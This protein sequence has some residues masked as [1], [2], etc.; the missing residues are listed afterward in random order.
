MP[1][2]KQL[3]SPKEKTIGQKLWWV[4]KLTITVLILSYVYSTFQ[5]EE[6]GLAV[7]LQELQG[8]FIS[9]NFFQLFLLLVL[10]P[11]NWALESLKWQLLAKKAIPITF[12]EALRSTLTGLAV[13]VALPAQIG[14]TL[15]RVGSLKSADRLKTIGAAVVS[16]GIQFYV[17]ILAGG[18]S[19]FLLK[20]SI[21]APEWIS[22]AVASLMIAL[23]VFGFLI[24]W[25]RS[26]LLL[27]NTKKNWLMR[28]QSYLE[29]IASYTL[30]D[31][32]IA[33]ILGTLR[34]LVFLF[35]FVLA[36]SLFNF[37]I[38]W[39]EITAGVGLILLAKTLIP[40]LNIFGD[41]GLREFTALY[42][43]KSYGL[44]SEKIVAATLLIWFIN[45]LGPLLVGIVLVWRYKWK[46]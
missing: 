11:V 1:Q 17:S 12:Y 18:I 46:N 40:A 7:I 42:V 10:V 41:L 27:W 6:K 39:L 13:G 34:Y 26:P 4:I 8:L 16:N 5:S 23:L 31:L 33:L 32:G 3:L 14:D 24:A 19:W 29:V 43:F 9:H 36:I 38:D 15:G 44:P 22:T 21:H 35:Q 30:A 45:I 28:V 37:G 20:D 2:D 25:F